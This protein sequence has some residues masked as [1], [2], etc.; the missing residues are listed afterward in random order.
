MQKQNTPPWLFII[1]VALAL[2]PTMATM[3][4]GQERD[5]NTR[6][7]TKKVNENQYPIAEYSVG[8]SADA[9]RDTKRRA[10]G[11]RFDFKHPRLSSEEI[12]QLELSEDSPEINLNGPWSH[13]PVEPALPVGGSSTVLV[14]EVMEAKAYLSEDRTQVYS[15][16]TVKVAELLLDKSPSRISVGDT[17][18]VTRIGGRVRLPSGKVLV[19]GQLGRS[20]PR[21]GG[22]YLLFL[23]YSE[24]GGD[25]SLLTGYELL[26]GHVQPLDGM[27]VGG[28]KVPQLAGYEVFAGADEGHFLMKVREA[29]ASAGN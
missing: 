16:F 5:A 27:S 28:G 25:F 11:R 7:V 22:N 18:A 10:R 6:Q 9:E 2:T 8:S 3:Q 12:Q 15:E 26:G 14:G 29:I 20:M 1:T 19:R 13:D 21:Q 23:S 24:E 17:V 4:S